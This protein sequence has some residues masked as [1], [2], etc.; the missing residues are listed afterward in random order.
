MITAKR[1]LQMKGPD[2]WTVSPHKT[3]YEALQ[4]MA[5]KNIGAV[6]VVDEDMLVGM[7]SERDYARKVVLQGK[8][9]FE[10]RVGELMT[11][12]VYFV[13][14]SRSMDDCMRLMTHMHIRH[15]PV[16]D[17]GQLKGIITIGDVVK[18]IIAQQEQTI[19]EL[20]R[21]VAGGY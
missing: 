5:E 13:K 1:L 2:T 12:R 7:F 9:S 15:L 11:P 17:F 4:L 8:S 20:E 18:A 6:P 10:T 21:Y 14:P 3:V 16:V 19:Q